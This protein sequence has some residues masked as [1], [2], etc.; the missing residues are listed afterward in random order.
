MAIETAQDAAL[1]QMRQHNFAPCTPLVF[2][3]ATLEVPGLPPPTQPVITVTGGR[4][5]DKVHGRIGL[6]VQDDGC[7]E[8]A[9]QHLAAAMLF[10]APPAERHMAAGKANALAHLGSVADS[11]SLLVDFQPEGLAQR[12]TLTWGADGQIKCVAVPTQQG[13]WLP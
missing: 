1:L 8:Q 6:G 4:F 5:K 3:R 9:A 2:Q 13:P 7:T 10:F 11:C 12:V